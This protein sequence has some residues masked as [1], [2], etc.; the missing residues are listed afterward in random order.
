MKLLRIS[1][2]GLVAVLFS[3]SLP[4]AVRGAD[5]GIGDVPG[6]LWSG[7]RA[8]SSVGGSV[9]DRVWR[10]ELSQ[11]RVAIIQL[12]GSAGSE[13]GLY[14]FDATTT[15]VLTGTPI[16]QSSQ[17]GGNQRFVAPLAAGTYYLNVNGRNP[18]RA[19]AFTLSVALILDPTPPFVSLAIAD[20][21]ARTNLTSVPVR[22]SATD[23]LTGVD[24]L[25]TR[26]DDGAWSDWVPKSAT[27]LVELS[28]TEGTHSVEVQARNGAGLLSA[29]ERDTIVLDLTSPQGTLL[30]P[31]AY[32]DV[33]RSRPTIRYQ[34][35]ERLQVSSWGARA[36][37][38]QSP[39]GEVLRG[40]A[41]YDAATGS[42]TFTVVDA[43]TPG[44]EYVVQPGTARD[45]AGNL[46]EFEPWVLTYRIRGE[47]VRE[48]SQLT[49]IA[50]RTGR[51]YF[52]ARN[53]PSGA[54]L[55]V[56]RRIVEAG[57]ARWEYVSRTVAAGGAR[58]FVSVQPDQ[59]AMYAIRYVGSATHQALFGGRTF[60]TL[61]PRIYVSGSEE[62][63]SAVA[64]S[65]VPLQ[66]SVLPAAVSD[67]TLT[68]YRC[69]RSYSSCAVDGVESATM[70]GG[71]LSATWSAA[72][73]NWAWRASTP[74]TTEHRA[75]KSGWLRVRVP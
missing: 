10:L 44:V 41:V 8:V 37:S 68:R 9:F 40:S 53:I 71:L 6:S 7:S 60:V 17:P 18:D 46:A 38:V 31:V 3:V 32:T 67:V 29:I 52:S 51:L 72:P 69:N 21:A 19:Y 54:E 33:A 30:A 50:D 55:L 49:T 13:L 27:V 1:V 11:P 75:A 36:L 39:T 74:S 22:I 5:A 28:A 34:F 12:Q 26:V 20:G 48:Q 43:L 15:S 2:L 73:G 63:R 24:G 59:S 58:Q 35:D 57:V 56:E 66:F 45:R 64:G 16:K 70:S 61:A 62:V 25:R 4:S 14:L 65:A 42:A 23:S 47:I